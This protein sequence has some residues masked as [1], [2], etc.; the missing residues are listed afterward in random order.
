[1]KA[2]TSVE[3][4]FIDIDQSLVHI[5]RGAEIEIANEEPDEFGQYIGLYNE[6][7]FSIFKNEF[8]LIN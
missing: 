8:T 4:E 7:W 3:I 6:R 5:P 1:M 2:I